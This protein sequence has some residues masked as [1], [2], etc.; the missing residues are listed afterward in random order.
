[1]PKWL[2]HK[3][4]LAFMPIEQDIQNA[5]ILIVDDQP[6]NT[7]LLE[8]ILNR[9]GYQNLY[10]ITDPRETFELY[11]Q[12]DFDLVLLDIRMPHMDGFEVMERLAKLQEDDEDYLPILV[13]TAELTDET[14]EKALQNGAKDFVTKPFNR[15]EVL[16]RIY[17]IL[18]VRILHKRLKNQNR[19]LEE[20]VKERTHQLEESRLDIIN[21][22]GQAAEYKD[23]ETGEHIIRMSHSAHMLAIAAGLPE[24]EATL[25]KEAAPMHDI[26][27]IGIPDE[28]LLKPGRLDAEEWEVMKTHANIGAKLL[29][30]SDHPLIIKAHSI[31]LT[32]HE[33][34]DGTGYPQGLKGEAIPIEGRICAIADVFDALTSVR[35][36]K[37]AWSTS[38]ALNFM[39]EQKGKHFDPELVDL[40]LSI[41][42]EVLSF[43]ASLPTELAAVED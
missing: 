9:A 15:I 6:Q 30:D 20:K 14:R 25:I 19:I 3:G 35:P 33:K 16:Q 22:L 28:I 4:E 36:Y 34:W 39:E 5:T 29:D 41:I 32:H 17:N 8:K 12:H 24:S 7:L 26:G 31:A 2:H 23:N 10:A 1:M 13:L 38:A 18:E 42:K 43:N 37:E 40:F 27:K 11:Q 21:R